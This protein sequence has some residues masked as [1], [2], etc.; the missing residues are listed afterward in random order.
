MIYGIGTDIVELE[1]IEK[2]GIQRL[3]KRILTVDE[4]VRMEQKEKQQKEYV[5]SRFAAKEAVSKALGV[6]IGKMVGFQDSQID[7]NERGAPIV[8]L[9]KEVKERFFGEKEVV[10]HLSLSH[11]RDY[12]VAMVVIE[13]I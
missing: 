1:R 10:I 2:V 5:A 8:H 6:G 11:C 3:A 4:R 12:A 9:R 13:E 7:R